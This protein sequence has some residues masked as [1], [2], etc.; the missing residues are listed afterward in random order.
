MVRA[1][2]PDKIAALNAA[3]A[4]GEHTT[5]VLTEAGY[6]QGEIEALRS[7]KVVA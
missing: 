2:L 7:S 5:D 3:Q 4:I 6:S 1:M